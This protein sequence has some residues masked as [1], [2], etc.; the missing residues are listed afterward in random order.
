M[1]D[2]MAPSQSAFHQPTQAPQS[3]LLAGQLSQLQQM[4]LTKQP[5][6]SPHV[7][8]KPQAKYGTSTL[9]QQPA[10]NVAGVPAWLSGTNQQFQ[11]TTAQQPN[12]NLLD[13][14]SALKLSQASPK[15]QLLSG[16]NGQDNSM[17]HLGDQGKDQQSKL[18]SLEK[19]EDNKDHNLIIQ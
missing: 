17:I 8:I 15:F 2:P 3:Q 7:L 10:H 12:R 18:Q 19:L 1:N 6:N 14:N 13:S 11:Q 16:M 4:G 9:P 5:S